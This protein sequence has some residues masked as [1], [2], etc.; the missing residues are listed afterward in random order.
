MLL[1]FNQS[2]WLDEYDLQPLLMQFQ[3][4]FGVSEVGIDVGKRVGEQPVEE[5]GLLLVK[6]W[7]YAGRAQ[8]DDCGDLR[9]GLRHAD[10]HQ[11]N[12]DGM[13][14]ILSDVGVGHIVVTGYGREDG[15][16]VLEAGGDERGVAQVPGEDVDLFVGC[17]VWLLGEQFGFG[18]D[19]DIDGVL[20]VFDEEFED[21]GAG[22][23]CCA[24]DCVRGHWFVCD[25]VIFIYSGVIVFIKGYLF[26]EV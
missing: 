24:E 11:G 7:V 3:V 4:F 21:V 2:S 17:E 10:I 1:I 9:F 19:V 13:S 22:G 12:D 26:S 25:V 8:P 18:A 23:A 15:V 6:V 20:G 16:G 5:S 14:G